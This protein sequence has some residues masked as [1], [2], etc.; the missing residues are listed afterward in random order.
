MIDR[1]DCLRTDETF[2][3]E[4][5][6]AVGCRYVVYAGPDALLTPGPSIAA[7]GVPEQALAKL[8][9]DTAG[10]VFLGFDRGEPRF[11][12]DVADLPE[13]ARAALLSFGRFAALGPI[14]D[15]VDVE[16]WSLLAQARALLAWNARSQHCPTCG[17]PTEMRN[18][19]YVRACSNSAC[20][21]L[22]FPRTDPAIIVRVTHKGRCLLARQ[23]AYRP[24]L[25]S[26][27]AGFIEPGESFEDA[28]RREVKEEVNL[29][30]ATLSYV[31]SQPW[32]FPTSLMVGF[33]AESVGDEIRVDGREIESAEW[34]T[35]D[36][37][38]HEEGSGALLL[39]SAKSIARRLIN[40]WLNAEQALGSSL[41][42]QA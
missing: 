15:P 24:G 37:V 40:D 10:S 42:D 11:A 39:P 17:A 2:I 3:Q 25:R 29:D 13:E 23:P 16:T 35:R 22:H 38:R 31:G 4:A 12:I 21:A 36:E 33:V 14:Q 18:A 26:I 41:L 9:A 6:H 8:G 19:G 27:L 30:L 34:W 32:P 5:R 20:G 7:A 28:V 1:S